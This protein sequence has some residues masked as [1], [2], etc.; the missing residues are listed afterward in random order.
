MAI[1][2]AWLAGDL[3]LPDLGRVSIPFTEVQIAELATRAAL[4]R[5]AETDA[6]ASID[7]EQKV[8][9]CLWRHRSREDLIV[10]APSEGMEKM[11]QVLLS[12]RP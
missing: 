10:I 5:W 2:V 3:S 12:Q 4:E 6:W 7:D 11:L 8:R 1:I 9:T